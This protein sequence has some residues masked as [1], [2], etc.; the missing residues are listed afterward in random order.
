MEKM[1][2]CYTIFHRKTWRFWFSALSS[3]AQNLG[4]QMDSAEEPEKKIREIKEHQE[5]NNF[6]G[7]SF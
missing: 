1:E 5:S 6:Y 4:K 7:R 3:V 2:T